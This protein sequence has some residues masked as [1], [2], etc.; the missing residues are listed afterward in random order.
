MNTKQ[1]LENNQETLN[2]AQELI[3]Y[4]DNDQEIYRYKEA[5]IKNYTKKLR[6]GIFNIEDGI[7]GMQ[8][9]MKNVQVAYNTEF[10]YNKDDGETTDWF[11]VINPS[12]KRTIQIIFLRSILLS[13]WDNDFEDISDFR[14]QVMELVKT[15]EGFY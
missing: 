4:M 1:Q 9:L 13:I 5:W 8:Y 12:E 2:K 11:I 7:K 15:L 3:L 14:K 10:G 6:K